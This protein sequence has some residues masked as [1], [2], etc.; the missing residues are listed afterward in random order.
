MKS[1]H[2]PCCPKLCCQLDSPL[3]AIYFTYPVL[4]SLAVS[5]E[6]P[7][8][9]CFGDSAALLGDWGR[10]HLMAAWFL[11][12]VTFELSVPGGLYENAL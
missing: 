6:Y 10:S 3:L 5:P 8:F 2:S 11:Q 9:H 7:G 4:W 1:A 12:A